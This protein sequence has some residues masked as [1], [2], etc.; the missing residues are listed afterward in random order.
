MEG[1]ASS[2]HAPDIQLF[3]SPH[4]QVKEKCGS[5]QAASQFPKSAFLHG[6]R[7]QAALEYT[8]VNVCRRLMKA[9]QALCT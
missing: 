5:Q 2:C 7:N 9:P 1:S 4:T 6:A 8:P 3:Y